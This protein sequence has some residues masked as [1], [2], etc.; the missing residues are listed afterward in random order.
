MKNEV[1]NERKLSMLNTSG[2]KP[3]EYKVLIKPDLVPERSKGGIAYSDQIRSNMQ[4]AICKGTIVD[5][6]PLAFNYD[7]DMTTRIP[8]E[9]RPQ[10]GMRVLFAKYAGGEIEG[11]D[12]ITYRMM[13]DKDILG[14]VVSEL[15][16]FR[17]PVVPLAFRSAGS[18]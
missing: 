4:M 9:A 6:S 8:P 7:V 3:W 12:R 5:M 11:E 13:N 16:E 10:I 17:E 18:E 14:E 1:E 15:N 2:I